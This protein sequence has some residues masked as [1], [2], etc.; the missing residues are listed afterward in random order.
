MGV[1]TEHKIIM[2]LFHFYSETLLEHWIVICF[3]SSS[4]IVSL[5]SLFTVFSM[6]TAP[7]KD[8]LKLALE[9]EA[10]QKSR[11]GR[12]GDVRTFGSQRQEDLANCVNEGKSQ[13][14]GSLGNQNK[15]L[16]GSG[17]R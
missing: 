17:R 12:Y 13:N 10:F 5:S 8:A 9:Y 11:R 2:T 15:W 6:I 3:T 4:L 14:R 1:E 16:I 7:V